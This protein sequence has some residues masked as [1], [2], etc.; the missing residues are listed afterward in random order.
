[1]RFSAPSRILALGAVLAA[2]LIGLVVVE[3]NARAAGREVL[4]PMEA[5][6]PRELLTGH[7][8][9]LQLTQQLPPGQPCPTRTQPY[10]EGGWIGL[11]A[12]GDHHRFVSAGATR[13]EVMRAGAELAVRGGVYCSRLALEEQVANAVTLDIGVDRFHAEQDEAQAIEKALGARRPGD[14]S[15]A[16]YAV[17]SVGTDGRARLKG[18]VVDGKRTDL[19]WF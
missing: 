17:V 16:A 9:A 12:A 1:M 5:V 4:L 13:A 19:T 2:L 7:Y 14:A 3:N 10:R 15:P 6:D 11:R 8:V 18:V